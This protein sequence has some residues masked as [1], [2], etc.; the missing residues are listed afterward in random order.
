MNYFTNEAGNR[1]VN[2]THHF[3]RLNAAFT[4]VSQTAAQKLFNASTNGALT[5]AP[6]TYRFNCQFSLSA[7][8]ATSGN[9]SFSLAGTAVIGSILMQCIGIDGATA[10]NGNQSGGVAVTSAFPVSMHNALTNTNQQSSV[11]GTFEV[12]TGGTVIPSIALVTAAAAIVA[13]GSFFECWCIG[14]DAVA[15]VGDWS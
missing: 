4:L 6:G 12:T 3:C 9:S 8:S 10:G 7:M 11:W 13:A 2:V 14:S 5:L 1:G 15:T